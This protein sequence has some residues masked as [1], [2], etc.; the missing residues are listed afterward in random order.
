M[1]RVLILFTKESVDYH[2]AYPDRL[3]RLLESNSQ[4]ALTVDTAIYDDVTYYLSSSDVRVHITS[5][6]RALSDY[7]MVYLRRIKENTAQAIAIGAYCLDRGIPVMDTE[8][9]TRPGSMGK[10]TQYMRLALAGLPFPPTVYAASHRLL[11][12]GFDTSNLAFPI[13][14]K[15]VSGSRGSDNHLIASR[16]ELADL[17]TKFPDVHFLIQKYIANTS[18]YRVWV[19]GATLGPIL[20]RS[21]QSGYLNNTSQGAQAVLVQDSSLLPAA[22]QA[23]CIRASHLFQRDVAGVD[24]V[25]EDDDLA[26]NYYFFEVNRAPQ[27]EATPYEAV[28]AKALADYMQSRIRQGQQL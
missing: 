6:G 22:V 20:Q 26:G 21:R 12:E 1:S 2:Q 16:S 8:I 25:F 7:D 11:M 18:D 17:L 23:D 24:V 19:C 27:I 4:P 9:A 5:T 15:S 3:R 13:I 10:L 14:V 28:K